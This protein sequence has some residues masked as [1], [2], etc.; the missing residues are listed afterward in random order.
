MV[1]HSVRNGV[2]LVSPDPIGPEERRGALLMDFLE[3][4]ERS[5]WSV[6]VVGAS[7]DWLPSY[8]AVGL[9]PSTSATR[10]CSTARSSPSRARR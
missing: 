8:E 10:P 7:A 9:R 2:C 4:V 3:H 1:A 5:G 6:A